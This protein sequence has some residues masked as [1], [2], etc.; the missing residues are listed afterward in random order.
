MKKKE[1]KKSVGIM[2]MNIVWVVNFVILRF[3]SLLPFLNF[4]FLYIYFKVKGKGKERRK[5][6]FLFFCFVSVYIY[7]Q[8]FI[9]LPRLCGEMRQ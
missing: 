5:K 2:D 6:F 1:E 4:F 7:M 9:Q 3:F 8:I